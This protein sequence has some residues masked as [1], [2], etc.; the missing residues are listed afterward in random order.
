MKNYSSRATS[1]QKYRAKWSFSHLIIFEAV[2]VLNSIMIIVVSV[3]VLCHIYG[4]T[5][6]S[7]AD[8]MF[9]VLSISD[10]GVGLL[11]Q[12]AVGIFSL[13]TSYISCGYSNGFLSVIVFYAFFPY[14]FSHILTTITA[15]DRL[16]V[17]TKQLLY[18]NF[19]TK[20]R[21][22]SII[23]F[24]LVSSIGCCAWTAYT[25]YARKFDQS[26]IIH[27]VINVIFPGIIIAAYVYILYFVYRRSNP[28]SQ[29][30]SS[31]NKDFNR[32]TRTIIFIFI[33]QII[34]VVPYQILWFDEYMGNSLTELLDDWSFLLRNSSSFFNGII[35]LLNERRKTRRKRRQETETRKTETETSQRLAKRFERSTMKK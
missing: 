35:L 3:L 26:D 15:A 31:G 7:R 13:C 2:S 32:L 30:K 14:T 27:L 19:V 18:E 24:A 20:R 10:I 21:L 28:M 29:C 22:K 34:C 9:L 16:F 8:L 12:T 6:R 5:R 33:T 17:I 11:S 25:F 4:K 1:P 23:A